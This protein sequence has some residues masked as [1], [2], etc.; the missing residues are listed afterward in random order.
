M[1]EKTIATV[2]VMGPLVAG[3]AGGIIATMQPDL[4]QAFCTGGM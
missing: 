4:F 1:K 2:R 3:M